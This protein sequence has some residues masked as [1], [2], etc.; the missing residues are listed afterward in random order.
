MAAIVL[1]HGIAQEQYGAD[2][3]EAQWLPALAAGV[4]TAGHAE[5]ADQLWRGQRPG[6]L[7][8]RMAFYGNAFLDPGAQGGGAPVGE[9]SELTERLAEAWLAIAAGQAADQ[10]DRLEAQRY[11]DN[12]ALG[13]EGAQGFGRKARPA[14]NALTKLK[15]FAPFG[16]G[17][18]GK[19]VNQSL[20]QVSKYLAEDTVREFAQRQ[21]LDLIGP[22]TRLVIG[23]SL[24]SVVAYEAMH[25]TRQPAALVT[26]GSP[27]AL[28]SIIY[29]LLRPQPP[30]VPA[31][32]TRWENLADR[33]DIV[34]AHLDLAPYFP[35]APGHDVV[36]TTH[37][38]LD[39][40]SSPHDA[41]HYL[42]KKSVGRIIA[43]SL[44]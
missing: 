2:L 5:L 18:A 36:P 9:E 34:A 32:L 38:E 15:W 4:R 23:H 39:N 14:A 35:P 29:P 37:P 26:L 17:M 7:E 30:T 3:L 33:D 27:L 10:R 8:V 31:A 19:F 44:S 42:T 11:L 24:G 20:T 43:E 13:A 21:V 40:G 41:A 16:F 22:E 1:V 28:Q 12:S 25:R 6:V